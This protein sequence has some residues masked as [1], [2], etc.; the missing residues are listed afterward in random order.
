MRHH[1]YTITP[2]DVQLHAANL[3]QQHL[4]LRDHGPKC[5][6]GVL[7]TLLFYAAARITSIAAACSA[8]RDAPSDQAVRDALAA[9]L[10]DINELQRR[11]NRA[12][13]GDLPKALRRRRQPLA[14]DFVLIPYHGEPLETEDEIYRG[15][16]KSGTSHFHAYATIYVVRKGQRFTLAL[17]YVRKGEKL[18]DVLKRLLQ[19][20]AQTG[21]KPR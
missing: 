4:K 1:Q 10:P 15:Q 12:L 7:M 3:C 11:I 9:T 8:L 19:R 16:P 13:A 6:A 2:K 5:R 20:A 17:T 18:E 14:I 21:V